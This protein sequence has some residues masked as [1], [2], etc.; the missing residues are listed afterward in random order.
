MCLGR[1]KSLLHRAKQKPKPKEKKKRNS[2]LDNLK[3]P[4]N[5]CA[6][7]KLPKRKLPDSLLLFWDHNVRVDHNS[8]WQKLTAEKARRFLDSELARQN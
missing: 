8:N 6:E 7:K 4:N 3:P 5:K 1:C 2:T